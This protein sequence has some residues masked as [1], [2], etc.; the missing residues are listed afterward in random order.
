MKKKDKTLA[1][2]LGEVEIGSLPKKDQGNDCKDDQRT[3]EKNG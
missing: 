3:W 1:E 2:E